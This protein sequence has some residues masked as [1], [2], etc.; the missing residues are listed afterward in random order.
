MEASA[1]LIEALSGSKSKKGSDPLQKSLLQVRGELHKSQERNERLEKDLIEAEDIAKDK[2]EELSEI[3]A[4]LRAYEKGKIVWSV[5]WQSLSKKVFLKYFLFAY[6]GTFKGEYGLEQALEEVKKFTR[7]LKIRDK[8]IEELTE[9]A[10]KLQYQNGELLE[11]VNELR[12]NLGMEP[13]GKKSAVAKQVASRKG[14]KALLQVVL[15]FLSIQLFTG[16]CLLL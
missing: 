5:Y 2:T 11:E 9:S 3:I 6:N 10:N 12:S 4:R 8:H 15:I 14:D 7:Q 16:F 13:K 1:S